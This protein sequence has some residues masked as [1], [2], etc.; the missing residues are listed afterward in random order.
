MSELTFCTKQYLTIITSADAHG[1]QQ[2]ARRR[3]IGFT[4]SE[5]MYEECNFVLLYI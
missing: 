2:G 4:V 5:V 1:G 3:F